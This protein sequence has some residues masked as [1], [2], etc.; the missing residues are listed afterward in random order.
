MPLPE[1]WFV[2]PLRRCGQT[3]GREW[4]WTAESTKGDAKDEG[5][6]VRAIVNEVSWF[7]CVLGS[8]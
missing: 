4:G 1:V 8:Y 7:E 5:E 2:S 6:G 3:L